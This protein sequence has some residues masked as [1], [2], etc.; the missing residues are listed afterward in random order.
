MEAIFKSAA[1]VE[2]HFI[3]AISVGVAYEEENG[4]QNLSKKPLMES[5]LEMEGMLYLGI[6]TTPKIRL[7]SG[8]LADVGI[9]FEYGFQL[10]AK[11]NEINGT[12]EESTYRDEKHSCKKCIE[13]GLSAVFSIGVEIQFLKC[14]WLTIKETWADLEVPLLIFYYSFFSS[15]KIFYEII[16]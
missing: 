1:K 2:T 5:T 3:G 14:K 13:G 9:P 11:Y 8:C 10:N 15:S 4:F 6:E 16:I 7:L 12:T